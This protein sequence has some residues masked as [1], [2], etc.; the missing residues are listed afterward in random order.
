MLAFTFFNV[1]TLAS[2][3]S[4]ALGDNK[5]VHTSGNSL[6]AYIPYPLIL[7]TDSLIK[8][9]AVWDVARGVFSLGDRAFPIEVKL[10]DPVTAPLILKPSSHAE[11]DPEADKRLAAEARIASSR[12]G[13]R[14]T[15]ISV[16]PLIRQALVKL[17]HLFRDKLPPGL[18]PAR[19]IDHTIT[20]QPGFMPRKGVIYRIMG[21]ELEEQRQ[22]LQELKANKWVSLTQSPFAAPSM[23]VTMKDDSSGNKQFRMVLNDQE[24]NSMTISAEYPLP[25]M[26]ER[27]DVLHGAKVF[28]IMDME[29]GFHQIRAAPQDQYKTAF[30][31]CMGQYEFEVMPFGLR[32]A[33]GT[34]QVVM[35]H[36][37]FPYIGKGVIAYLDDLLVYA[38]HEL[39]LV[40]LLRKV[41]TILSDNKMYPK[42]FKCHIGAPSIEYLG[43]T[44]SNEGITPSASR[45]EEIKVWP[46]QL[47]NDTCV[48][49]FLG[50][51]NYSRTFMG[52]EFADVAR[53]L[54]ELLRKGQKFVWELKHTAAVKALKPRL[55]NFTTLQVPDPAK[56]YVLRIDASGCAIGAALEQDNRP[57]GFLVNA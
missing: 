33:P 16:P 10:V 51:V 53:P 7:R 2:R 40:A 54:N 55:I 1:R 48:R 41:L 15:E 3:V 4:Y 14:E 25:T 44:V 9:H 32:G 11:A 17:K 31:T 45:I 50:T 39:S 27:L 46:D 36:M 12:P 23:I 30:R 38:P 57:L 6:V 21:E 20:L 8:F 18:P 49:Q 29:Q 5:Q 24:L 37:F 42:N 22:I 56:H 43:Y 34:F 52:P 47:P 19:V 28:T 13:S 35:T 26:Q